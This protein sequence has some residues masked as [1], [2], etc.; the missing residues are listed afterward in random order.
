MGLDILSGIKNNIWLNSREFDTLQWE[1]K[2]FQRYVQ[3][4]KN[5]Q[6]VYKQNDENMEFCNISCSPAISNFTTKNNH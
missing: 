6:V 2:S 5:S 3:K 4:Q 1:N